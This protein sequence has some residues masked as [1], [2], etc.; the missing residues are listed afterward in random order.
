MIRR[1]PRSTLFPY[2]T[3]FRSPGRDGVLDRDDDDVAQPTVAALGAPEDADHERAARARV[4][5]N[6]DDRFLLDHD[7]SALLRALDDLDHPPPL[8]LRQRPRL[9]DAHGVAQLRPTL[10]VGR[11]F[12]GAHDL[13]AVESVGEAARQE[14]R[15]GLL[16]LVAHHHPGADLA[17]A[18]RLLLHLVCRLLL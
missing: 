4:V 17:L 8:Q 7:P 14:D 1:P 18:P 9:H 12:L 6:L 10:V 13:L 3:L 11:D 5:G 16:P 2:T 15:D